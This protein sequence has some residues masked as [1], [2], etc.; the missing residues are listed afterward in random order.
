MVI[1]F[2]YILCFLQGQA[3]QVP[4]SRAPAHHFAPSSRLQA[5]KILE[6]CLRENDDNNV[7]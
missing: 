4:E 6:S 5:L 2:M 7:F 1:Y 3:V